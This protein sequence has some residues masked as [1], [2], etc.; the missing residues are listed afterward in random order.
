LSPLLRMKLVISRKAWYKTA[1]WR[2]M[3]WCGG[4]SVD[5]DEL[6]RWWGGSFVVV[7]FG[8]EEP[9][10]MWVKWNKRSM[11]FLLFFVSRFSW[12]R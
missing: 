10:W 9:I 5:D 8:G 11:E 1:C 4:G 7:G 3:F 6:W 2:G 12:A